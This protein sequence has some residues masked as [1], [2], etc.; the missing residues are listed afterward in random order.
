MESISSTASSYKSDFKTFL[1]GSDLISLILAVY[2]GAVCKEFF[3]NLVEGGVLPIV[4]KIIPDNKYDT[5]EDIKVV[6]GGVTFDFG[7]IMMSA[8]KL[9][10]GFIITFQVVRYFTKK[11]I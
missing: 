10:I 9:F 3:D 4:M 7:K 1:F 2:L 5:F 8:I 6:L 11:Y